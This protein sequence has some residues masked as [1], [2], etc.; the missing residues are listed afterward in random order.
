MK[1]IYALIVLCCTVFGLNAQFTYT[2]TGKPR[3]QIL[4]K[5]NNDT[6][7]IINVELFP[8]IAPLHVR[9][10]DSLVSQ[11]FY[12]SCAFHRVVPGFVIQ[13]GDPNSKSGPE[14]TWG[15]G[16]LWQPKVKAEFSA[17]Q[18]LR[19]IL[20]AARSSNINSATSQ[21]FICVA[22]APN[23]N[24][25]YSVYGRV[26]SGMSVVDQIVST[27]TVA[28]TQRPVDK[29]EMFITYI[30]SNDSVPLPPTLTVPKD[31]SIGV[32]T[33]G[34][35]LK[36]NKVQD[37][38]F[39]HLD[40]SLDSLFSKDTVKSIDLAGLQYGLT[41]LKGGRD[42]YWRVKANNGGHI[43]SSGVWRFQTEP[44]PNTNHDLAGVEILNTSCDS[45][46]VEVSTH[47]PYGAGTACPQLTGY[48]LKSGAGVI[49]A[50]LYYDISGVWPTLGCSQT[51]TISGL[52]TPGDYLQV[53]TN[54]IFE[55]DTTFAINDILFFYC[56]TTGIEKTGNNRLMVYPNPF[57]ETFAIKIR[58]NKIDDVTVSVYDIHGRE[59]NIQR[60]TNAEEIEIDGRTLP[61]GIY[62]VSIKNGNGL[63]ERVRVVLMR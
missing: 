27:P 2:Y 42:Y 12:D 48:T 41:P 19:G 30:G 5:Q 60:L 36:W 16:Q 1:R 6:L 39:Y 57:K 4:T 25:Q 9:N 28:G 45:L 35:M 54:T 32:D 22:P 17:A 50:D 52:V 56:A 31:D 10:F 58:G 43:S 7:G 38:V 33:S 26:T 24:G 37:A 44:T 11:Q 34:V 14:S 21:F 51:N 53:R 49:T 40:V 23:L 59:M 13:G 20:S 55:G 63:N 62:Y 18:H 29:V 61:A 3:F 15:F 8:R 47:F 46:E